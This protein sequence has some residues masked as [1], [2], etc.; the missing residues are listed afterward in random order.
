M[1]TILHRS[2]L[3]L[4]KRGLPVFPC[5]PRDK[6]PVTKR[7]FLDATTDLIV[8]DNWWQGWPEQNIGLATGSKAK[9]AVVDVDGEGG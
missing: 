1:T 3:A 2:A 5:K 4:A 8:V 9:L 6:V 7:G